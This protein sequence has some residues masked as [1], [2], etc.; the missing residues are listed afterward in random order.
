[1]RN[2]CEVL[3][4]EIH[5]LH[6]YVSDH[7]TLCADLKTPSVRKNLMQQFMK[8][9]AKF[10]QLA[11]KRNYDGRRAWH[12]LSKDHPFDDLVYIYKLY[13]MYQCIPM[14]SAV[15]ERGFSLH[16]LLKGTRRTTMHIETVDAQMRIK[17]HLNLQQLVTK[18][19]DPLHGAG[20]YGPVMSAVDAYNEIALKSRGKSK[21]FLVRQMQANMRRLI[22]EVWDRDL[23]SEKDSL[24]EEQAAEGQGEVECADDSDS[25]AS[26]IDAALDEMTSCWR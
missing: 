4:I 21:N 2:N 12:D 20:E 7:C 25:D 23:G 8:M 15:V 3:D 16:K 24:E 9:K 17:L 26:E 14:S 18:E 11:S 13:I 1:M 19:W 10:V 6:I 5:C 22:G